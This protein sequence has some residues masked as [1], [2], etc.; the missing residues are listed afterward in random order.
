M[1]KTLLA[2]VAFALAGFAFAEGWDVNGYFRSGIEGNFDAK[3]VETKS[4]KDGQYY[5]NGRSRA[6]INVN[7]D[8]ENYGFKF[9]FQC[10]GFGL[11]NGDITGKET[12]FIQDN[13][14]YMMGYAKFLDGRIITEA[15]KLMDYITHSEARYEFSALNGYGV[16]AVAVP[17]DGLFLSLGA[18]TYRAEKYE[19]G[20][21][22]LKDGNVKIG[23]IKLNEKILTV[24]AKYRHE[25]FT[26]A[27]GYNLAGEAY[28]YFGLTAVPKLKFNIEAKFLK[29]EIS[30]KTDKEGEKT[31]LTEAWELVNYN[32]KGL[33]LP[34]EAGVYCHQ[35]IVKDNN[36]IE[37]YPHLSYALTKV[38]SPEF[39]VGI[40]R[41][42]TKGETETT[43]NVTPSVKFS[44]GKGANIKI[45]YNYDK[46][47]KHAVGSTFR[48]NF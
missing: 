6:R 22:E 36:S 16:R 20:D 5:G 25:M 24:S 23:D 11:N 3:D 39:E 8:Q 48:V 30:K 14:K 43:Y 46:D 13:I 32:F 29:D 9:R 19:A 45:Y 47:D 4:Y 7:F 18:T 41:V 10:D 1:K 28:G 40:K 44:V 21:D 38:V 17:V 15:G 35:I 31:S 27:G 37:F 34:L 12:W 42:T 33:G 26:I 2:A